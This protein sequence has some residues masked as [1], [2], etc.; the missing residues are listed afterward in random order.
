MEK[1][2]LFEIHD[3]M[4][5]FPRDYVRIFK[6]QSEEDIKANAIK[7]ASSMSLNY[8]GGT[9]EFIKVMTAEEAWREVEKI[10]DRESKNP[11]EDSEECIERA[12][13]L[14]SKC[15]GELS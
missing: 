5:E 7:Y 14:Y 8:S 3:Y 2:V 4:D 10:I 6:G 12:E 1:F 11:A 13:K 15:Y 9:T